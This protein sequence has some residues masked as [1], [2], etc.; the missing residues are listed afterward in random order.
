M[1]AIKIAL[2]ILIV[3]AF[4]ALSYADNSNIT[5]A[6][7]GSSAEGKSRGAGIKAERGIKNILFGWTDIPKSII[8]VTRDS[9]NP[10]W[11][12]TGGTFKGLGKAIPRTV[13][14]IA[15]VA[16]FPLADY[17]RPLVKPDEIN[18]QVK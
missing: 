6:N 11:G 7:K 16:T 10:I 8:Q 4:A 13:S 5:P 14:G 15:D 9:K 18:T 12:V 3:V 17:D 2:I 1:K